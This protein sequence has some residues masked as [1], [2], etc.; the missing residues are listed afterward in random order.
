M[1]LTVGTSLQKVLKHALDHAKIKEPITLL[2]CGTLMQH[3]Y[4]KRE[5]IFDTYKSS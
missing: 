5:L 3:I 4:W 1:I 2:G